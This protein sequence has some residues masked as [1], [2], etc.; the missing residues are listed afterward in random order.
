MQDLGVNHGEDKQDLGVNAT[1]RKQGYTWN[2]YICGKSTIFEGFPPDQPPPH[3]RKTN[4]KKRKKEKKT[5]PRCRT[6]LAAGAAV[7]CLATNLL[8]PQ[9]KVRRAVDF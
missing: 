2:L 6:Q 1:A 7:L 4:K 8:G 5:I 3:G 9:G